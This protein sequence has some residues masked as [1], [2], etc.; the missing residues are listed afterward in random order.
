MELHE[1]IKRIKEVMGLMTEQVLP[2]Q[3]TQQPPTQQKNNSDSL[4]KLPI[5]KTGSYSAPSNNCDMLHAFNDTKGR[6]VGG[7]NDIINPILM[8]YYNAGINPDITNVEVNIQPGA[9]Y[10]VSWSVTIDESKDGVAYVGLYS[11]GHGGRAEWVFSDV[12]T[13]EGHASIAQCKKSISVNK[14]G[15]VQ[16]MVLVK[17]FEYNKDG[18]IKGCQVNQLFYKYSLKQYPSKNNVSV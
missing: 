10:K 4:E 18:K 6:T 17:D 16:D 1:N 3:P 13:T 2:Q 7:M 8:K 11:R 9:T 5:V 15:T 12:S 14:R